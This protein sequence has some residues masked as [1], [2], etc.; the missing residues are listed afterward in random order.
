VAVLVAID[1]LAARA[2]PGAVDTLQRPHGRPMPNPLEV[3]N[4]RLCRRAERAK[5][6]LEKARR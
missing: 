5:V 6:E 4:A 2:G 3:E 1:R